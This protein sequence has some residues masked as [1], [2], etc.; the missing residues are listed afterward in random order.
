MTTVV[1]APPVA[2]TAAARTTAPARATSPPWRCWRGAALPQRPDTPGADRPLLTPVLFAVV[3]AP[4]LPTSS[5]RRPA[6]STT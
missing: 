5:A 3:I 1:T 2:S 6:A 4:A